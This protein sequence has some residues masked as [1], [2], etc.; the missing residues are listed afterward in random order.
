MNKCN[1]FYFGLTYVTSNLRVLKDLIRQ[2]DGK[3]KWCKH[4]FIRPS[5]NPID[6]LRNLK[7]SL[8]TK[9]IYF[10]KIYKTKIQPGKNLIALIMSLLLVPEL[11]QEYKGNS[12]DILNGNWLGNWPIKLGEANNEL[13]GSWFIWKGASLW[14]HQNLLFLLEGIEN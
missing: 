7:V 10:W 9:Y 5:G 6:D 2:L 13:E 8:L 1:F 11:N 4:K 12:Q 3:L 14:L